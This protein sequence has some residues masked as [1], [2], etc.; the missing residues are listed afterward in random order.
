MK[1]LKSIFALCFAF[2]MAF[3]MSVSVKA[4]NLS[5]DSFATV[6]LHGRDTDKD[7]AFNVYKL[8]DVNYDA[9]K[10][11]LVEPVYTWVESVGFYLSGEDKYAHYVDVE[12]DSTTYKVTQD[13]M[14]AKAADLKTLYKDVIK[15]VAK[16]DPYKTNISING[17]VDGTFT[18]SFTAE[19]GLYVIV[20]SGS[21]GSTD[22]YDPMTAFVQPVYEND[23]YT[24]HDVDIYL[25]G[26]TPSITKTVDTKDENDNDKSVS[27]GDT[28]TYTI[29]SEIP[30][31]PDDAANKKYAISDTL[32]DGLTFINTKKGT[33]RGLT[34]KIGNEDVSTDAYYVILG[35]D[36][37]PAFDREYVIGSTFTIVFDY[38]ELCNSDAYMHAGTKEITVTYDVTVNENA[39]VGTDA[40]TNKAELHY[41]NDPYDPSSYDSTPVTE[42]VYTYGIDLAKKA[43]A[44]DAG[45]NYDHKPLTG[46]TFEV[47][48]ENSADRTPVVFVKEDT[49]YRPLTAEEKEAYKGDPK[50]VEG[51]VTEVT[52]GEN[53]TLS[54]RGLDLGTYYIKETVAPAGYVLPEKDFV[55]TLVGYT[56]DKGELKTGEG[57]TTIE[58]NSIGN[59][60]LTTPIE[61]DQAKKNVADVTIYN[62]SSSD[63]GFEL[64]STG[65]MGTVIFTVGGIAVMAAAVVFGLYS[66]RKRNA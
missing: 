43:T 32:S 8:I 59:V 12:N 64:P 34:V 16:L 6:T 10:G 42:T 57:G 15:N 11:Q 40:T 17:N 60:S 41:A 18:G 63:E 13:F 36:D 21:T 22:T 26:S 50:S 56:P 29:T 9:T 66:S 38:D 27:V 53:G 24:L 55:V 54:I 46:A 48:T 31:Y 58:G 33:N 30:V 5:A 23:A 7:A 19:M 44:S 25:K 39:V 45:E 35:T 28:L 37:D 52:V 49:Y 3:G 4:E 1:K 61:I 14:E 51:A 20:A 65:G 47:Y 62:I 2:L